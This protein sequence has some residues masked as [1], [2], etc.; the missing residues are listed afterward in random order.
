MTEE[1]VRIKIVPYRDWLK[2]RIN[3]ILSATSKC[4]EDNQEVPEEW[5]EELGIH[6]ETF[7]KM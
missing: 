3:E 6:L 1:F 2:A 5:V 4:I 7:R